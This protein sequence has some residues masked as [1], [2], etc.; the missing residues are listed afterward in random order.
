MKRA[1]RRAQGPDELDIYVTA[2]RRWGGWTKAPFK[3]M[4]TATNTT[5]L[6]DTRFE[7]P[8]AWTRWCLGSHKFWGKSK[9]P[10]K[11]PGTQ[12]RWARP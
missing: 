2:L 3:P 4:A 8:V 10:C 12:G 5:W 7:W 6:Q 1:L 9:L 11:R